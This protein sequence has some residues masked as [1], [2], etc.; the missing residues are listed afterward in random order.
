MIALCG[1]GTGGHLSIVKAV[2]EEYNKKGIKPIYIGS[3]NGQDKKWFEH[4]EGFEKA[5]FLPSSGVVNKRGLSKIFALA[6]ILKQAFYCKK[7][8]KTHKID[9]VFSVGGY[10]SAP[11]SFGAIL[12]R[13]KLFIHE[14]NAV[15]GRLNKLLKPFCTHLF[16]S[17]ENA[18]FK[19]PYPVRDVFFENSRV[20]KKLDCVLFLGGSQGAKFINSLARSIAKDL[21]E[22]NIKIIHQCGSNELEDL[23]AF[24]TKNCIKVDL[25]DFDKNLALK[26]HR[27]DFAITRAG[28]SSLWELSANA[29]PSLFIPFPFASADHQ[30]HNAKSL[31]DKGLSFVLRQNECNKEKVLEIL[32]K[33]ENLEEISNS[34][35]LS[36]TQGGALQIVQQ[37]S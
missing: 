30:Y 22:K 19:T 20:R 6:T 29:L 26:M 23:R 1:G 9:K 4:Y 12:F 15:L 35:K 36:I 11:A 8:F 16:S 14:Q 7:I 34:L 17:Y 27:A 28:A 5:Y 31:S 18:S 10:S 25:F 3:Q 24:Y 2:C 33:L 21:S 13:K 32:E 37:L